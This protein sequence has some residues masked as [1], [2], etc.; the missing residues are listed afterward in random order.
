MYGRS[1]AR[2]TAAIASLPKTTSL[3][4]DGTGESWTMVL[5]VSFIWFPLTS[6]LRHFVTAS[7]IRGS[8]RGLDHFRPLGEFVGEMLRE[9]FTRAADRKTTGFGHAL[10]HVDALHDLYRLRVE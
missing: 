9:R 10:L 8:A 4:C 2:S 1:S 6:S 3:A 7:L 5:V